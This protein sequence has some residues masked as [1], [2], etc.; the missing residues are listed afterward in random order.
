MLP[1]YLDQSSTDP[2]PLSSAFPLSAESHIFRCHHP[3]YH[4]PLKTVSD[5]PDHR[6]VS[7]MFTPWRPRRD[8]RQVP[9]YCGAAQS[10][11]SSLPPTRLTATIPCVQVYRWLC[12]GV[13]VYNR[14]PPEPH[15][16]RTFM[17][18]LVPL[19]SRGELSDYCWKSEVVYRQRDDAY[20]EHLYHWPLSITRRSHCISLCHSSSWTS[21]N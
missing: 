8:W 5:I 19:I 6:P 10:V 3:Q 13:Q 11:R 7:T 16:D 18:S 4:S 21:R 9:A 12:T 20:Q 15:R 2:S 14:W 17:A 1:V